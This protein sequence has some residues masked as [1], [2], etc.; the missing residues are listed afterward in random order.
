MELNQ[1]KQPEEKITCEFCGEYS[2]DKR[3]V[4][5]HRIHCKSKPSAESPAQEPEQSVIRE[6]PKI[7]RKERIPF[8]VPQSKLHS[9][10]GD[11]YHYRV[12]NDNWRREPGRIQRALDAG[13]EVVKNFESLAVGT[14]DDGSEIKGVL[15]RIPQELYDE[16]QKLKQK[17]VDKVDQAIRG[18]T[19]EQ[20]AGDKRYIPQ[21]IRIWSNNREN[22]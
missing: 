17:E 12:F 1:E 3:Q 4:N 10:S 20:Q 14:N 7:N 8:G 19:I 5:M 16:D 15:M 22:P 9:P 13:Y 18:G 6:K 21:G 2:G 11:G